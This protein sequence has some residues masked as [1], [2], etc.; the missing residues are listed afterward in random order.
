[1]PQD[2]PIVQTAWSVAAALGLSLIL[3][4]G[5]SDANIPLSLKIP[6]ITIGAGGTGVDVHAVTESFD[7]TD[8]W[9]GTQNALL[10]TI[11]LAQR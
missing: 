6:A 8:A 5:S 1:M 2:A 4:E 10:L 11:A 9:K 3:S 7:T